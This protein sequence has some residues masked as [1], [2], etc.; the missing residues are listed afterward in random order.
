MSNMC[1]SE[2]SCLSFISRKRTMDSTMPKEG[3]ERHSSGMWSDFL[4]RWCCLHSPLLSY[5]SIG[6]IRATPPH[7]N[8]VTASS[9]PH[10]YKPLSGTVRH[11]TARF[12]IIN[13]RVMDAAQRT[14]C[15]PE[16]SG[17]TRERAEILVLLSKIHRSGSVVFF[18]YLNVS[19]CLVRLP[20]FKKRIH[21]LDLC[22]E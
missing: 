1:F 22:S 15:S 7:Y 3:G 6:V 5:F 2:R 4:S 18:F 13:T 16:L 10:Q 19:K 20:V 9:D 17:R 8:G 12:S 14:Y 11:S 21:N